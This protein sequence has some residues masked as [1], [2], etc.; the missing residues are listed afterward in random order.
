M[1]L[2]ANARL[3]AAMDG[4]PRLLLAGPVGE[5]GTG[6]RRESS[7]W[8]E[9]IARAGATYLGVVAEDRLA[10]LLS[11]ADVFVM[12]T[13]ELEMQG[14]AALEAQ[15]CGT[16]V[17]ATDQAA[18]RDGAGTATALRVAPGDAAAW[19]RRWRSCS[20]TRRA[21]PNSGAAPASTPPATRGRGSRSSPSRSTSRR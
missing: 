4:P 17:V 6:G 18:A 21:A 1:L 5:F 7:G 13:I 10:G 15:A 8:Q 14:M 3:R 19:P 11:A 2:E 16:P 9:A 12:P 20:A